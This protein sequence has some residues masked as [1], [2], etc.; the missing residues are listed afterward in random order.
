[1]SKWDQRFL[2]LAKQI[3]TWSKDPSTQVGCVVVGPDREIRVLGLMAFLV[4][5]KIQV[6]G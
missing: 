1:M 5:L 2:E 3:S 6:R 4:E